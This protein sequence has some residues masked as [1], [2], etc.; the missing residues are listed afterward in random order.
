MMR[1]LTEEEKHIVEE[2]LR[3]KA[4]AKLQDLRVTKLLQNNLD[5]F[6]LRWALTPRKFI[7]IY[8]EKKDDKNIAKLKEQ[9]FKICDFLYFMEELKE[10]HFIRLQT[11][12]FVDS[13]AK[14]VRHALY[15]STKYDCDVSLNMGTLFR[16]DCF[17]RK[18]GKRLYPIEQ[19][20]QEAY[21]D[22]VD[23]LEKYHDK[24]IYPLP[25]LE[26]FVF[27][28]YKSIEQRNFEKQIKDGEKHHREQMKIACWSFM[29][30]IL[31]AIVPVVVPLVESQCSSPKL[32]NVQRESA[33]NFLGKDSLGL[34][35]ARNI[36]IVR[37]RGG[38]W[39][40]EY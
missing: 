27:H 3:R 11:S 13:S 33:G 10:N 16:Q 2:L 23:L 17:W 28:G 19:L 20:R 26:D 21:T 5:C 6:A 31:A 24:I 8:M 34:S 18:D 22:F 1:Q 39:S 9:Y 38:L 40:A 25:L 32:Y 7:K 30:A 36:Q 4:K 15:D 35:E 37:L 29:A 14:P 12:S